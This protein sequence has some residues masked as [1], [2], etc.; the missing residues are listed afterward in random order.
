MALIRDEQFY[1]SDFGHPGK[2]GHRIFH[3]WGGYGEFGRIASRIGYGAGDF[4]YYVLWA[5][6]RQSLLRNPRGQVWECGV[7]KGHT[8]ALLA[9]IAEEAGIQIHL[10]DTFEGMPEVNPEW[11]SHCKGDF[12]D[13]SL[14]DAENY[15]K[16]FKSTTVF[17]QGLIPETFKGCEAAEI[18]FAHIDVDLHRSVLD[19]LEFIY[20]RLMPGCAI[21]VDDYGWGSCPGAREAVEVYFRTKP[22]V[23]LAL[24]SAQAIIIK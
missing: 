4:R 12:A 7:W 22:V 20:P 3:P 2:E 6:S 1:G 11:D 16:E 13:T 10:F 8:A 5:L 14:G 21:V 24:P 17:H 23:P 9:A 15:L 19:C 18:T